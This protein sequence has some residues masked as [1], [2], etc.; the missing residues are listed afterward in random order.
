VVVWLHA[1]GREGCSAF[2]SRHFALGKVPP[3]PSGVETWCLLSDENYFRKKNPCI[4][5]NPKVHYCIYK[6]PPSLPILRQIDPFHA[7]TSHFLK[8]HLG[9][10]LPFT[11]G[12]S[13]FS[14]S[15]RFP[16]QI[17]VYTSPPP[18]C[19]TCLAHIILLD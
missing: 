15:L 12:S 11:P 10:M 2:T 13:K 5:W 3:V 9:I 7:P 14:L 16:H 4:L 8:L 19:A 18:I 17:P 6:F 1:L